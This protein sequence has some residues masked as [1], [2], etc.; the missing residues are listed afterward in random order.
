MTLYRNPIFT[1]KFK[2]K[3][4]LEALGYVAMPKN[5]SCGK[6]NY[7]RIAPGRISEVFLG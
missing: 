4:L 6:W 7:T 1:G 3:M 5:R 2:K